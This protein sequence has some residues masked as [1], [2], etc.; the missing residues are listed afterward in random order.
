MLNVVKRQTASNMLVAT[1]M[2]I[3]GKKGKKH[4]VSIS[5]QYDMLQSVAPIKAPTQELEA[6]V[7]F[8]QICPNT[9]LSS[10]KWNIY[11]TNVYSYCI[12]VK[13]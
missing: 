13:A 12:G 5:V 7:L 1:T 9:H 6:S 11:I 4:L 10:T 8:L 2:F 3:I